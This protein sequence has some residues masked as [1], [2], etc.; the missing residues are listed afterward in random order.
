MI[1][2]GRRESGNVIDNRRMGGGAK[3]GAGVLIVGAIITYLTGGNP[4]TYI[5][6]NVSQVSSA[7]AV[8]EQTDATRKSFA[9]VVLADTEDVWTE[10]FRAKGLT[11]NEPKMVLFRG[12]TETSCGRGSSAMGP[13]YCPGDARVYL[14]LGFFD[15]LTNKLGAHGDF[16]SAYVIAHEV[17]HHIQN[18]LGL[19]R[20]S[21]R[22][23]QESISVELQADCL[24]GVWASRTEKTGNVE[25]GDIQEA[26]SA[27]SAVGDDRLQKQGQGYVVPD[28]FTHGSSA[29]R[30][31][32]FQQGYRG[33]QLDACLGK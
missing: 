2:N 25:A 7:P 30:Q 4:L 19:E 33:Q 8:N 21:S 5:T 9:S 1:F 20:G 28:S 10:Q 31:A 22:S 17:G 29:Q 16:A 26:L 14:D 24:A 23:N 15:E 12:S 27:A 6:N 13:F 11:Y 3:A 18:L 32:A